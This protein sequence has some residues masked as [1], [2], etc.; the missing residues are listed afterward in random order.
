MP[1]QRFATGLLVLMLGTSV[2]RAQVSFES[3]IAALGSPDAGVRIKALRLLKAVAYPEAAEPVAKLLTDPVPAIRLEAIATELNIFLADKI[4]PRRRVGYVVEVRS[5]IAAEA[6]FAAGPLALTG[7]PVPPAV[8]E[9]LRAATRGNDPR[10][11][12]E[13]LYAFGALAIDA[14]GARAPLLA[15][16]APDLAGKIGAADPAVRLA[17]LRVI[18]RVFERRRGDR[19]VDV[20][21]GDAVITALNDPE[22]PVRLAAMQALGAMR[23]ERAVQP[24]TELF[25]YYGSGAEAI[26]VL[27]ALARIGHPASVPL[28][29]RLLSSSKDVALR[30]LAVDG[31]ARAGDRE[32]LVEIQ[33]LLAGE[34]DEAVELAGSF[35]AARL[36]NAP[37]DAITKSLARP[38]LRDRARAYLVELVPGRVPVF[39]RHVQDP[40]PQIRTAIVDILGLSRDAGALPVAEA[41]TRDPDPQVAAAAGRA[42]ARLRVAA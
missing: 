20:T 29:L 13:A 35:A 36:S 40:D 14:A 1:T 12:L 39:L 30:V 28:F 10:V 5:K 15:A 42:T 32:R 3:T 11:A 41:L 7:Q 22:R 18:G 27:D 19:P 21:L 26:A 23:Y 8:V 2:A 4:V 31:I 25:A 17:A 37:I 34:H 24:L 38:K 6:T 33:A 16:S 9:G